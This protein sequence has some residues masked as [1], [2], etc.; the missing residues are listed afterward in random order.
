MQTKSYSQYEDG[1]RIV[2]FSYKEEEL[3]I[4]GWSRGC[5]NISYE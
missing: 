2:Y 5:T 3:G 4:G 1:M